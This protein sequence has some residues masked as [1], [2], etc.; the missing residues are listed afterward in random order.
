[1]SGAPERGKTFPL[2]EA[3]KAQQVLRHVAGLAPER[4]PMEAFVGMISDEVQALRERGWNDE[5]IA[6]HIRKNSA[7]DVTAEEIAEH[8]ATEDQRNR[9]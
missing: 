9:G 5:Q 8:Y 2:D 3:L 1:M 6:E 4:F 7:I